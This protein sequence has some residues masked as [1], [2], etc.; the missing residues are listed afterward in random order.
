MGKNDRRRRLFTG[1]MIVTGLW[2]LKFDSTVDAGAFLTFLTLVAGFLAWSFKTIKEWRR[3][4]LR[5]ANNGALRLLLKILRERYQADQ[6]PVSLRELQTEFSKPDRKTDRKAYCE[7]DF[8]FKDDPHFERAIYQLHWESKIDFAAGDR[9]LF[10]T[11]RPF[12][13]PRP[14]LHAR[15][16]PGVA[17]EAF[18]VAL[19]EDFDRDFDVERLGRLAGHLDPAGAQAAVESAV[20]QA[21]NDPA[22]LRKL[23]LVT[24]ALRD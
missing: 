12:D 8:K 11:A 18:K 9:V 5:E 13:P 20:D 14:R 7:R 21:R 19:S 4:A 6:G 22:R 1:P 10:R 2:N 23:L 16:D 17:V 3:D 15:V 24:A